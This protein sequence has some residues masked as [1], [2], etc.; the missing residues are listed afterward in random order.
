MKKQ[1]LAITLSMT[2]ATSVIASDRSEQEV[3]N[4]MI[5]MGTGALIGTLVAGPVGGVVAGLFGILIADDVN[6]KNE[7]DDMTAKLDRQD[8]QLLALHSENDKLKQQNQIQLVS[9]D[10][11]I[12]RVTQETESNIQFR[13]GSYQIEEHFKAQLDLVAEGLMKNS[14]LTVSLSGFADRRGD[15]TYNQ[16]LSEQRVLSVKQYLFDK[17]VS[18][19]QIIAKSFG[20]SNP[21]E[22]TQNLES[23][24][25]DRRVVI[26]LAQGSEQ[27]TAAN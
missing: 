11:Q 2:F 26:R 13:T 8:S 24:F 1:I 18:K 20:E 4:E 9:M 12:E 25:F 3:E 19:Q 22:V 7:L 5:G 21:V 23:D 10:T 16:A 17:G 6:D 27:M 14:E 15:D